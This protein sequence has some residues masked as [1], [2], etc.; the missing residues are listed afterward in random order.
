MQLYEEWPT[1]GNNTLDGIHVG[2]EAAAYR[3]RA[4]MQQIYGNGASL[5][6]PAGA[7]N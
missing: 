2:D 3:A 1:P 7:Q 6:T 5:G 4:I